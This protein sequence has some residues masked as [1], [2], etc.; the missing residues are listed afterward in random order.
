MILRPDLAAATEWREAKSHP[1]VMTAKLRN[2]GA[3]LSAEARFREIGIH[4]VC[5]LL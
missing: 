3:V 4:S 5:I 2:V 1:A